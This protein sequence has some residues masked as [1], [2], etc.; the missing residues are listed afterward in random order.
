MPASL[1]E[2]CGSAVAEMEVPSLS[3]VVRL[4]DLAPSLELPLW[5]VLKLLEHCR[6]E[7]L[8]AVY[9][10][11]AGLQAGLGMVVR[12][13]HVWLTSP[14][15]AS[16]ND[17]LHVQA[18]AG[19]VYRRSF[20]IELT[21]HIV[22]AGGSQPQELFARSM[23]TIAITSN[24]HT[25]SEEIP[26]A[27]RCQLLERPSVPVCL[28]EHPVFRVSPAERLAKVVPPPGTVAGRLLQMEIA[29]RFADMDAN[30][31]VNQSIYGQLFLEGLQ[32][33]RRGATGTVGT[34]NSEAWYQPLASLS[35]DHC[36]Q[37]MAPEVLQLEIY[38]DPVGDPQVLYMQLSRD[39]APVCRGKLCFWLMED[40]VNERR[41]THPFMTGLTGLRA[42]L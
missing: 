4:G 25:A 34:A 10:Y 19:E 15:A 2:D 30:Q 16:M 40:H 33:F 13:Q 20:Q 9:M 1:S 42:R 36:G 17:V 31:H 14:E 38:G 28:Q 12:A 24:G 3:V 32:H 7:W 21:V 8:Q 23:A 11:M 26:P 5:Q 22:R 29:T 6:V 41:Q 27:A 35:L 18:W 37:A 39:Q